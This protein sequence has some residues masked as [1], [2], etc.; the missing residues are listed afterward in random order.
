MANREFH[1]CI[2][3]VQH[4]SNQ[5]YT[6]TQTPTNG[7]DLQGFD[8]AE[9]EIHIGTLTNVG[10]S[11]TESWTFKLQESDSQSSGFSDVT[12]SSKV[13]VGSAQS[14]L[15][16]PDSSSGV[17]LTVDAA[18]EDDAIYR[19]GYRGDKRYVRVVSTANNTP[20]ST[21]LGIVARLGHPGQEPVQD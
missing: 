16:T 10:G 12:D 17:F 21:P 9:F 19:I 7:V 13:V 14:P 6:S 15:T 11:P 8:S 20:G 18:D 1:S 5:A 3:A 2:K 4:L